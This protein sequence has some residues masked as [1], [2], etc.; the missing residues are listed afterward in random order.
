[1]SCSVPTSV[2]G[3]RRTRKTHTRFIRGMRIRFPGKARKNKTVRSKAKN[4]HIK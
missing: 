1:M 4:L 2:G 3:A